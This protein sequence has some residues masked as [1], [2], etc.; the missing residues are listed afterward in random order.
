M[1]QTTSLSIIIPFYNET[2]FIET[3]VTS[4]LTQG[5]EDFEVIIVNDNPDTFKQA[6]FDSIGF[7]DSVR[8]VHH[9][10][11]RGLPSSR[12]T[13]IDTAKGRYIAFLD[14]DDYYLPKGLSNHMDYAVRMDA[15]ITHAQTVIT[16]VNQTSGF[17]IPPDAAYLNKLKQGRYAKKDVVQAGFFI[18]SSWSSIYTAEFLRGKQVRFDE[19]QVKFEDRIFVIEALLAADSLAIMGEP[20]R[21]WR[22]RNDS[23]TTSAKTYDDQL[24]KLNLVRKSVDLWLEKGGE[25][26]RH[27]AM[28]EFVRQVGYM[29]TKNETSPWFGAFGFSDE[30]PDLKLTEM[31]TEYFVSLEITELD[32]VSAFDANSPKYHP[33]TTGG[34]KITPQDLFRFVDAVARADYALARDIINATVKRPQPFELPHLQK[35]LGTES[36]VRILLHCGLHKTGTTHIQYQLAENRAVLR[37]HGVLFP[38]TGFGSIPGKDPVRPRGLP[39]HQALISAIFQN[40]TDLIKQLQGEVLGAQ[41]HTVIISAENLSQPDALYPARARRVRQ[42]VEKLN[43]IGDVTP[44]FMYRQPDKWFESYYREISGNGA[45]LA[46][47]TPGEFLVN[48][49]IMLNFGDIISAVENACMTQ[50]LLFSFEEALQNYHDITFAFL[51]KCGVDIPQERLSLAADTRYPSTCN[52]QLQIAR[53]TSLLVQDQPTRQ[54]ILRTFYE[55]VEDSGQQTKLF[56]PRERRQIVETFCDASEALFSARGI[57]SPRAAWLEQINDNDLPQEVMIPERYMKAL[58]TAGV[59]NGTGIEPIALIPN[60]PPEPVQIEHIAEVSLH[61]LDRLSQDRHVFEQITRELDYMRNSVSWRV[62]KP[63]RTIMHGYKRLRGRT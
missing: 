62:T 1:N 30:T 28:T 44:V 29:I 55:Q 50:A 27:W 57:S 10:Q 60:I 32:I 20:G 9:D 18:E 52:A 21:V 53:L 3:A 63:L 40:D 8:V 48:N 39:G 43:M 37:E 14:A 23:I 7:P 47:Q 22:K 12:N 26:S 49:K 51:D 45:P 42:V 5:L 2:A 16:R 31:L 11:N 13:G 24:L 15:E 41:C 36:K 4:V 54:N 34:G 61:D 33:D 6:Y 59:M 17:V 46:Y 58:W 56:T 38:Q 35:T 19:S 25:H